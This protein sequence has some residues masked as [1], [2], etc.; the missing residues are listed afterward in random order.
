MLSKRLRKIADMVDGGS[1]LADIGTDHAYLPVY[2]MKEKKILSA[3]AGDI[4][5]GPY[6]TAYNFVRNNNMDNSIDV[7]IGDGL[8]ILN[9]GETDV[10]VIAGMGGATIVKIL[11]SCPEVVK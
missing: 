2:L 4:H 6:K 8:T 1:K 10:L 5:Y 3:V 7:R 9:P 11:A